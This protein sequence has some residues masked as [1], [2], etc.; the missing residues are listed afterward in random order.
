M[1]TLAEARA[2]AHAGKVPSF[3]WFHS[4]RQ[5]YVVRPVGWPPPKDEKWR[6]VQVP[7]VEA[8]PVQVPVIAAQAPHDTPV[9]APPEVPAPEPVPVQAEKPRKRWWQVQ[10]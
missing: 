10:T 2:A 4:E 6:P 8:P 3:I 7:A 5:T 1:K 9:E